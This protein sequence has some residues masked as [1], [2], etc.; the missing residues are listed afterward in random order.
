MKKGKCIICGKETRQDKWQET[1]NNKSEDE[2]LRIHKAKMNTRSYSKI[3]QKLFTQ[4]LEKINDKF[5]CRFATLKENGKVEDNGVNDE[6]CIVTEGG[7]YRFL[8]FYI[9]SIKKCIEFDGEYYHSEKFLK[10]NKERDRIRE[11]EI[12]E[13]VK[14]IKILHI[15]EREF[16]NCPEETVKKCLEFIY[17]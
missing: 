12:K 5:N 6:F 11:E 2:K 4:I 9:P 14:D 16:R 17:G 13:T 3:S 10:G 7:R 15:N 1:L 8:D